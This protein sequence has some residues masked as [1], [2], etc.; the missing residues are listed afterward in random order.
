MNYSQVNNN[1]ISMPYPMQ[2]LV[3]AGFLGCGKTTLLV[4]LGTSLARERGLKVAVI[5]NDF[6][7]IGVDAKLVE[8]NGIQVR[9]LASG[10]IC[11]TMGTDFLST[12]SDIESRFSPD[13]VVVEPSGIANPIH[14]RWSI[15]SQSRYQ[16]TRVTVVVLVDGQRFREMMPAFG[17]PLRTQL[18]AADLVLISKADL[19]S[20]E[21]LHEVETWL[22]ECFPG[23]PVIRS[24]DSPESAKRV[25]DA[26]SAATGW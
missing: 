24:S 7:R 9:E 10:C 11:C 25:M 23:R 18:R 15:E 14:V 20:Q 3:V 12:L 17:I 19:A 8:R 2:I 16:G 4:A 1:P 21:R 13:L 22:E 5:E 26:L 6:G